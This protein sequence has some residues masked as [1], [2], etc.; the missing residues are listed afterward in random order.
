MS[1]HVWTEWGKDS[2]KDNNYYFADKDSIRYR[3]V[4]ITVLNSLPDELTDQE[5]RRPLCGKNSQD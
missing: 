4:S 5:G 2:I 1:C 3:V